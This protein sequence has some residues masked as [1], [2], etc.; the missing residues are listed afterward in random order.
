MTSIRELRVLQSCR[1]ANLVELK[2]VVTGSKM[3]RF[4]ISPAT[5]CMLQAAYACKHTYINHAGAHAIIPGQVHSSVCCCEEFM[6]QLL[7]C[8]KGYK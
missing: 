4:C 1:H 2:R 5:S 6:L 3:D 8:V 7:T